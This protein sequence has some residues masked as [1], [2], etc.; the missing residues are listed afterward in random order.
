M[1][2][3]LIALEQKRKL[4]NMHQAIKEIYKRRKHR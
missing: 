3:P 4:R 2:D 1:A